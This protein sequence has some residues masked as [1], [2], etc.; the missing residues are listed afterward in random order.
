MRK[1]A[2]DTDEI[3]RLYVEEGLRASEI[4]LR[5]RCT[6][7]LVY[8]RLQGAKVPRSRRSRVPIADATRLYVEEG[9]SAKAIGDKFG[10]SAFTVLRHLRAAGVTISRSKL[11]REPGRL[12]PCPQSVTFRAYLLG[13][14]WGDFS[15][16]R[17]GPGSKMIALNSSTTRAEQVDLTRQV[18]G[19]FGAVTYRGKTLRVALD[20]SFDFLLQ[21]YER[22]VPRWVRGA[23]PAAAFAAG[24]IDAEGSFG[25]YEGRARFTLAAYDTEVLAW[26][27]KWCRRNAIPSKLRRIAEAGDLRPGQPP[28]RCDLWRVNVNEGLGVLRLIATLDPYLQHAGRRADAERA[29]QSVLKRLRSRL[30]DQLVPLPFGHLAC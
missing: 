23:K 13:L 4:A 15:T 5:L 9:W 10:V 17:A 11:L 7:S 24:Y 1:I 19:A 22:Q 27:H 25:V 18:L 8:E 12:R 14:V 29:R 26:V 2:A 16:E 3:V 30:A 28:F 20:L 21:K 6:E